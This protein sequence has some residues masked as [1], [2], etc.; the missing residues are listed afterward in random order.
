MPPVD[1]D[2]LAAVAA[3]AGEKDGVAHAG[4]LVANPQ[5]RKLRPRAPESKQG[6]VS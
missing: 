1:L 3:V 6:E 4:R 5:H 2:A